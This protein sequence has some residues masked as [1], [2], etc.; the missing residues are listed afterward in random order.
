M[1]QRGR[2]LEK[3][4]IKSKSEE[5]WTYAEANYRTYAVAV[6]AVKKSF[7]SSTI[8]LVGSWPA[9]FFWV[10]KTLVDT[11]NPEEEDGSVE[12]CE[13]LAKYFSIKNR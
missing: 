2:Q 3:R 12:K 10:V 6:I 11:S 7:F 4:W 13:Q 8:V 1:K 5:D 9:A